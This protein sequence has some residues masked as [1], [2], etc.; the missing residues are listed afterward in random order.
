MDKYANFGTTVSKVCNLTN[1]ETS[2]KHQQG[3]SVQGQAIL[4][5]NSNKTFDDILVIYIFFVTM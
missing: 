3:A 4:H 2:E 1:H 5:P